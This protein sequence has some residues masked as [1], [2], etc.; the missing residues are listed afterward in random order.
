MTNQNC[1]SI[2]K[3]EPSKEEFKEEKDFAYQC[4]NKLKH[5]PEEP[6]KTEQKVC[7]LI[8]LDSFSKCHEH[9]D[10]IK[11]KSTNPN[12]I[13]QCLCKHE[14]HTN[15]NEIAFDFLIDNY[16]KVNGV[17]VFANSNIK[18]FIQSKKI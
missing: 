3:K 8:A 15:Y 5:I 14:I 16:Q 12:R 13:Q 17:A 9:C 2:I 7:D 6:Q 18:Y 11:S 1:R 4:K 10:K